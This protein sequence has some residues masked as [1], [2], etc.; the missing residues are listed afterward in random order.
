MSVPPDQINLQTAVLHSSFDVRGFAPTVT[1]TAIEFKRGTGI[2]PIFTPR[3][4]PWPSQ[5]P[6]GWDGPIQYTL[7]AFV[8]VGGVWH[9]GAM[10]EFWADRDHTGANWLEPAPDGPN[11]GLNNWQANWAYESRRPFLG[12]M[13]DYVP[14]AGDLVGFMLTA[15]DCRSPIAMPTVS[16]RTNTIIVPLV[17]EGVAVPVPGPFPGPTPEPGPTPPPPPP[18]TPDTEVLQRLAAIQASLGHLGEAQAAILDRLVAVETRV[19]SISTELSALQIQQESPYPVYRG[20]FFGARVTL[21]P[22]PSAPPAIP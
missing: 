12:A 10:L 7:W 13:C 22:D 6:P 8:Q 16:E 18:P 4:A 15:G 20:S 9:G 3:P 17:L 2:W 21:V 14:Q 19:L 5:V 11:A 1:L